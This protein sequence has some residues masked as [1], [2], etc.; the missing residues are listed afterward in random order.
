LPP[1]STR[2]T[3]TKEMPTCRQDIQDCLAHRAELGGAG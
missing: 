1:A 2:D 3:P